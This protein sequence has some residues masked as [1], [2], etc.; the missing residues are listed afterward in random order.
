[1]NASVVLVFREALANLLE[2]VEA[3]VEVARAT[4]PAPEP[5]RAVAAKLQS[6]FATA[7]RLVRGK[8]MGNRIDTERVA[9]L[10]GAIS[11]VQG[12]YL[13][14]CGKARQ[15]SVAAEALQMLAAAAENARGGL[16]DADLRGKSRV[17]HV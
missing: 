15:P 16:R 13:A 6:R 11:D 17:R 4:E 8:F 3:T 2:S 12:A 9:T 14:Y 1:M 5:T 7:E 10:C